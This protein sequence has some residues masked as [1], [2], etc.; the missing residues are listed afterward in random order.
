MSTNPP[1]LT[2]EEIEELLGAYALDAVDPETA[3][4][5][6]AHLEECV[7][8]AIEVA[9]HHEVVGLLANTG[10][11]PPASLWDGIASQLDGTSDQSWDRLAARLD[12]PETERV[13][14]P[15][16]AEADAGATVTPIGKARTRRWGSVGAG[17]VAAAAA[18]LALVFGLQVHHLNGQVNALQSGPQLSAAERAA[19]A[20]PTTQRIPLTSMSPSGGQSTPATIVLTAA[21]TGFLV[22]DSADGLAPLPSDRTYQLWGVVGQRTISLG[23]LGSHP[24][25]VPFSVAGNAPVTEFAVTNEAA[26]GVVRSANTPVAVG[27]F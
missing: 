18:V 6:E 20:S 8:C 17:V 24:D 12:R 22:D 13:V 19:L 21:G 14:E 10:G 15:I 16:G 25:I 11:A 1:E 7:R 3:A 4:V 5:I 26:G 2:H 23:L 27:V 9:Q